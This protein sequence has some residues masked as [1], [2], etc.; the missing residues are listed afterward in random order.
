VGA[1]AASHSSTE[2]PASAIITRSRST[3]DRTSSGT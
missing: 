1:Q 2:M 3:G